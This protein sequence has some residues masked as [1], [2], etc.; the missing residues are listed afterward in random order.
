[1]GEIAGRGRH[2]FGNPV[3]VAPKPPF[4]EESKECSHISLTLFKVAIVEIQ[5]ERPRPTAF[6]RN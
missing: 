2:D 6:A 1:M 3:S 4:V 5:L